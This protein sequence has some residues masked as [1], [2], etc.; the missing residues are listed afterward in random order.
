MREA[1]LIHDVWVATRKLGHDESGLTDGVEVGFRIYD[2]ATHNDNVMVF[3]GGRGGNHR[4]RK[5]NEG[6]QEIREKGDF[7]R[8]LDHRPPVSHL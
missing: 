6:Q 4:E 5:K 3:R 7:F 8:S 1:N 2:S